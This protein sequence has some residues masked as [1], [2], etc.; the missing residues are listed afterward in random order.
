MPRN[1]TTYSQQFHGVKQRFAQRQYEISRKRGRGVS[2][3]EPFNLDT[4]LIAMLD[5][6][7]TNEYL[8]PLERDLIL[9]QLIY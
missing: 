5:D 8:S 2:V 9:D 3:S 1:E 7:E 4:N 6:N